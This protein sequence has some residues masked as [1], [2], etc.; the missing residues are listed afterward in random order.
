MRS[1]K[2]LLIL[3]I[4]AACCASA[5][6]QSTSGK[7]E[8][9]ARILKVQ[10]PGMEA[11][12][13]NLVEQPA[14]EMLDRAGAALPQRVPPDKRDAVGREI[15]GDVQKFIEDTVPIV[16]ERVVKLAPSTVGAMMEEKFTEAE[17][18]EIAAM[19]ESPTFAKFQ[20]MGGDLQRSLVEKLIVETKPQVEPRLRSLEET[21]AKRLGV[22]TDAAKSGG[23]AP[24]AA[25]PAAP[26]APAKK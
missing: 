26:K 14:M 21:I 13:R 23:P 9:V 1:A 22:N 2:P 4:A 15:Q 12:A 5:Q 16:R 24:K 11:L 17:L 7:K 18:K 6:A 10:Q 3:A 19:M 25:A 20:A 8:I